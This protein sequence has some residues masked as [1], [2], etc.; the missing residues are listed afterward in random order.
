META[1]LYNKRA[2]IEFY[3]NRYSNHYMH[4]WPL[5]KKERIFKLIRSLP[6]PEY[7]AALDFGC[8][9]GIFT[10][11]LKQALPK[12]EVSGCDISEVSVN[13]AKSKFS[14]CN[15]FVSNDEV[16]NTKKFN[17]LFTHHVLEHVYDIERCIE[18]MSDYLLPGSS[19]FH[20]LPCGNRDSF[21]YYIATLRTDGFNE[22][23][24]NRLFFED[25]GH[26]RRLTSD[27]LSGLMESV[28]YSLQ[29]E[30]YAN[31]KYGSIEW[32]TRSTLRFIK[33]LTD[34]G[35]ARDGKA[36]TSLIQIRR[37]LL[38]EFILRFPSSIFIKA[39]DPVKP[40]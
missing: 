8:G 20:I 15:F 31:H 9:N 2:S 24:G 25:E 22:K 37:Y 3:E 14:E 26:V 7:G 27:E 35:K 1:N 36:R 19:M 34:P 4:E 5:D 38:K 13:N 16:K 30:F 29:R 18:E 11:V 33:E 12:W 21:E 40:P 39:K 10:D 6:L 23:V 28:G 17:F 32:M